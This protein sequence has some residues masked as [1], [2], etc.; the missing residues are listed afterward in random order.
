MPI[1]NAAARN[2]FIARPY[3]PAPS[4]SRCRAL[5][6]IFLRAEFWARCRFSR[7]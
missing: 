6:A 3:K 7:L 1:I 5:A 4:K 2:F